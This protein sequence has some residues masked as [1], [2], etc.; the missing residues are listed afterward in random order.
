MGS[1][2]EINRFTFCH[3]TYLNPTPFPKNTAKPH[4]CP[5]V[6]TFCGFWSNPYFLSNSK[7]LFYVTTGKY[8]KSLPYCPKFVVGGQFDQLSFSDF[9]EIDHKLC[10]CQGVTPQKK[11]LKNQEFPFFSLCFFQSPF[12]A[13]RFF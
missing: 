1:L 6:F 13:I 2:W 8:K 11:T 7:A 9:Y 3:N 4:I 5:S 10:F 12:S